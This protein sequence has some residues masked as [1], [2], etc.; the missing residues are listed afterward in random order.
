MG[1]ELQIP[2]DLA[3]VAHEKGFPLDL[4]RRA[5][6][7]GFPPSL[8]A[9]QIRAGAQPEQVAAYL[10]EQERVRAGGEVHIP[11]EVQQLA[12]QRRWPEELI[13]R[14]VRAGLSMQQVKD[15]LESG[16]R[17]D[18]MERVVILRE[19]AREAGGP[20]VTLEWM[21]ARTE[22]GIRVKPG[23]KGLTLGSLNVG[24]YGDI[25]DYWPR[26]TEM[27]RGA[28]PNPLS[29]SM[30]Y[31]IYE[32]A[33]LWADH[34]ADL[35][36]EAIQRQWK[37]ATHIPWDDIPPLPEPLEQAL[38]QLCTYMCQNAM[39]ISDTIGK[40]LKE[41]SYGYHEVKVYMA[42]AGFD[43][44]RHM[45]VFRKRAYLNGVGMGRQSPG[46]YLRPIKDA[47]R[48]TEASTMMFIFN[49]SFL[50]HLCQVGYYTARSE[51]DALIFALT[52][53]DLAR[54]TA[55]G[56]EHLRYF[57]LRKPECRL[58]V[59]GYLQKIEAFFAYEDDKDPTLQE[60]L[61]VLLG[62][63]LGR[64]ELKR[65]WQLLHRFRRRWIADYLWRLEAAGMPERRQ[66]LF[67]YLRQWLPQH[68][69]VTVTT[70]G[71]S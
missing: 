22:W 58:E 70:G 8:I 15:F 11:P 32:K 3:Q 62:G 55:Y 53:Q 17:A 50:M 69:E 31:S 42:T 6:A 12:R 60:A 27:P 9:A 16:L 71:T 57:L 29:P 18:Q 7:L 67:F 48:W 45:D 13:K 40:W 10:D 51:G 26:Q 47:R 37:P 19:R 14:A 65:G 46:Y 28:A 1:E 41:M 68:Q 56:V 24:S 54:Q 4:V 35:Y 34:A 64:E 49:T 33:E 63:G 59:D 2:E 21:N 25:P 43:Y 61:V 30:G 36:E 66:Y 39:V 52:M 44:A 5:L 23:K 20:P 38:C